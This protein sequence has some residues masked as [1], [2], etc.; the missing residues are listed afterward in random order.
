MKTP[1]TLAFL[2]L[3]V[4]ATPSAEAV[5]RACRPSLSNAYHCPDKSASQPQRKSAKTTRP[6]VPS[7]SNAYYC[8]GTASESRRSA[9]PRETTS[10]AERDCR[11]SLSNGFNC[12]GRGQAGVNQ[13][14]TETMAWAHCPT[15]T[16]VW[17]N[18]RS[19]IYHFRATANYGSTKAGA[20]MCEQDARAQGMRAA[21][22]EKRPT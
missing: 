21:K 19:G 20:Y 13:Y 9:P 4:F 11:P 14:S 12:A 17:L 5:E 2:A 18:T 1:V 16:V 8:P 6:C 7:L 3:L 22:N 10:T 15:D